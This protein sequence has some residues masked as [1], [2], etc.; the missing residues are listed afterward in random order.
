[1][2]RNIRNSWLHSGLVLF[3]M[4][5]MYA[6]AT[7]AQ[8]ERSKVASLR[9]IEKHSA[10]ILKYPD[11]PDAY[12]MR[13]RAYEKLDRT[14]EAITDLTKAIALSTHPYYVAQATTDRGEIYLKRGDHEKADEDFSAVIGLAGAEPYK[15][16]AFL[17]RARVLIA[18]GNIAEAGKDA[19]EAIKLYSAMKARGAKKKLGEAY[20]LRA[21]INCVDGKSAA[22]KA[23]NLKAVSLG[24]TSSKCGLK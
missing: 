13:A 20:K 21:A 9:D 15:P 17:N 19:N 14:E 6:S 10:D 12:L 1:M 16:G 18:Q 23:D 24:A 2:K 22:A 4:I 8:S 3:A 11:S 5:L 7:A